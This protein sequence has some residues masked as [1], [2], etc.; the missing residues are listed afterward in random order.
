MNAHMLKNPH[1]GTQTSI[2]AEA[3]LGMIHEGVLIHV[4]SH[5]LYDLHFRDERTRRAPD[6]S[7]QL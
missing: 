3:F 7:V 1:L 2:H 4:F 6:W 5:D